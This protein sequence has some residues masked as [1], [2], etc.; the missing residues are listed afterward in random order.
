M[1]KVI[2]MRRAIR[3]AAAVASLCMA[4]AANAITLSVIPQSPSVNLGDLLAVDVVAAGLLDGAAPSIGTYDLNLSYDASLLSLAGVT[5]GTGLDVRGLGSLQ[6][7]SAG[8]PGLANV[9][10]LSFDTVD[11][12]N[13]LQLDAFRLFTLTFH[14]DAVGTSALT[15]TINAI[16]DALGNS[17][18]PDI[19]NA[20]ASVTPVPLPAAGWLF[21]TG[22]AV[23]AGFV[24]RRLAQ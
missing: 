24:R 16:G 12:L 4:S 15:L 13:Q 11:D 20:S 19:T 5:F 7:T 14:A 21:W 23:T 22:L 8:T 3:C 10:E 9:F 18:S 6:D 2:S 1:K 17:L